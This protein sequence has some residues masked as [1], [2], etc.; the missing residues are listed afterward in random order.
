MSETIVHENNLIWCAMMWWWLSSAE[1]RG[2]GGGVLRLFN[3]TC[4]IW[5]NPLPLS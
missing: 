1:E 3:I 5:P 2:G 4:V